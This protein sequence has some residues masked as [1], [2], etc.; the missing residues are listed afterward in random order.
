MDDEVKRLMEVG[1]TEHLA[2]PFDRATL[3][4]LLARYLKAEERKV[5]VVAANAEVLERARE[6]EDLLEITLFF[7]DTVG[8]RVPEL[9]A[10]F[11]ARQWAELD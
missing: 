5:T 2:K 8:E 4:A 11:K 1:C 3:Y 10:Y 9:E 6:D 7:I